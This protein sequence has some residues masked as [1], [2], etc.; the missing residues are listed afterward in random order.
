MG[1]DK[2]GDDASTSV[3]SEAVSPPASA[4]DAAGTVDLCPL[5]RADFKV[6][7]GAA[8][9]CGAVRDFASLPL[10]QELFRRMPMRDMLRSVE[11]NAV[12]VGMHPTTAVVLLWFSLV[13][14][15]CANFDA[16]ADG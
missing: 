11:A 6:I 16:S 10:L 2:A 8:K 12:K 9:L 7:E 14:P 5:C 3:E 15:A 13:I 4:V 1:E